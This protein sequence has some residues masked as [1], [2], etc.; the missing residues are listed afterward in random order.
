MG[1]VHSLLRC[2]VYVTT[3]SVVLLYHFLLLRF[4][5]FHTMCARLEAATA[6]HTTHT[7]P[8]APEAVTRGAGDGSDGHIRLLT[9]NLWCHYPMSILK[10]CAG[11][12]PGWDFTRRLRRFGEHVRSHGGYDVVCVQEVF[13][14]TLWPFGTVS[15]FEQLTN[16]MRACG[17]VHHT[18]PLLSMG[19]SR[20]FGQNSGLVVY[21]RLP[22]VAS[23]S[24]AL[25]SAEGNNTKVQCVFFT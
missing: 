18:N 8:P 20:W 4:R 1:V 21:S 23:V 10:P 13:L 5:P 12:L 15:N 11:A 6:Q 14:F 25:E 16:E 24:H 3:R 17:L 19:N 9:H 2:L 7:Q 22:I